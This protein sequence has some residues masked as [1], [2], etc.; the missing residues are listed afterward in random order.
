MPPAMAVFPAPARLLSPHLIVTI[1]DLRCGVATSTKRVNQIDSLPLWCDLHGHAIEMELGRGDR[2][3]P[4]GHARSGWSLHPLSQ[5]LFGA[6]VTY[7][8]HNLADEASAARLNNTCWVLASGGRL[9][10]SG[11]GAKNWGAKIPWYR[12]VAV[13]RWFGFPQVRSDAVQLR[14]ERDFSTNVSTTVMRSSWDAATPVIYPGGSQQWPTGRRRARPAAPLPHPRS[15]CPVRPTRC[16][17]AVARR[18][19]PRT[20]CWLAMSR[21]TPMGPC[22]PIQVGE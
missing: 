1:I 12:S 10:V 21:A 15:L 5:A 11:A 6:S 16:P 19:A 8:V 14:F 7:R 17:P 9:S 3:Y 18:S 13:S 4:F 22:R 20:I 2:P